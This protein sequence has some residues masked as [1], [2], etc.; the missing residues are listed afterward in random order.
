MGKAAKSSRKFAASGK[1]KQ[2]IQSRKKHQQMQKKIQ[3][4]RGAHGKGKQQAVTEAE[5]SEPDDDEEVKG[6]S[7]K[8]GKESVNLLPS[9]LLPEY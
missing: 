5:G 8:A 4:R 6:V 1:L 9:D 3:G 7:K 2:A